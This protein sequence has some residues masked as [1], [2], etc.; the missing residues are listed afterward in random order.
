MA[1][2]RPT[3][4]PTLTEEEKAYYASF[5]AWTRNCQRYNAA[6]YPLFLAEAR[7]RFLWHWYYGGLRAEL[8]R[9]GAYKG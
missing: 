7:R 3:I 5:P 6:T 9:K 1:D 4:E 8:R 2:N